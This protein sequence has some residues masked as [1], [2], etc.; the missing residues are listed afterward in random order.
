MSAE[1]TLSPDDARRLAVDKQGLAGPRGAADRADLLSVIRAIRCLQL[2]P[3]QVVARS[4]LLVLWSRV[5]PYDQAL[6]RQLLWEERVLFEYWAHMAS[7]V[8]TEDYPL[9]HWAM[10]R[11]LAQWRPRTKRWLEENA[12]L[13]A[14]I[15]ERLQQEGPLSARDFEHEEEVEE[16][17]SG[18]WSTYRTVNQ[19]LDC[20]WMEGEVLVAGRQGRTRLWHLAEAH[21]DHQRP[22]TLLDEKEADARAVALAIRALGV[23]RIPHI[24][25]HFM[26]NAYAGIQAALARLEKRGEVLRVRVRDGD[27]TWR[28]PWYLHRDDLPRLEQLRTGEW[29]P[30]TELLSPFDNLICDRQRTELLFD[31]HYRMEIYVPKEKRQY[32]YYVLPILQ[33]DRF[34]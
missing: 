29:A 20:M 34:I 5:G 23:A 13:R 28:G 4:P 10:R 32:G 21:L 26:R 12:P 17:Q 9:F 31:F 24:R 8:L 25:Y 33:G 19:M 3:I 11:Q 6:L 7:I 14:H 22:A 2:D 18:A 16:W 15:R 27:E 30:R 1:L